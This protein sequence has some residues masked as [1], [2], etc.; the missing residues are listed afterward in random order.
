MKPSSDVALSRLTESCVVDSQVKRPQII[1]VD[2]HPEGHNSGFLGSPRGSVGPPREA[3]KKVMTEIRGLV[4]WVSSSI[5]LD[6]ASNCSCRTRRLLGI[7][8]RQLAEPPL[9]YR[10]SGCGRR[11][12]LGKWW[13]D[14][15]RWN[16][17][18]SAGR[19]K[20]R[21]GFGTRI[22]QRGGRVEIEATINIV[23]DSARWCP[24]SGALVA[25]AIPRIRHKLLK[26]IIVQPLTDRR[27]AI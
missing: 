3:T 11:R 10:G 5:Q 22:E 16:C 1:A 19:G 8:C 21:L 13:H 18:R 20:A 23:C 7:R 2:G 9:R 17:T 6:I 4:D 24:T 27:V 12:G 14:Y 25:D 26:D 15:W